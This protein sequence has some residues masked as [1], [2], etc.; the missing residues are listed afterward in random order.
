MIIF[1]S[2]WKEESK[3]NAAEQR[4]WQ[5]ADSAHRTGRAGRLD[6][7][8]KQSGKVGGRRA[9]ECDRAV[10]EMGSGV[11]PRQKGLG[12]AGRAVS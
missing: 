1:I 3:P 6:D 9:E 7:V 4:S 12:G 11:A 5:S 8:C 10:G 2:K